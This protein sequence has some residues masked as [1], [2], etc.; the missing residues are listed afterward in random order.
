MVVSQAEPVRR[1]FVLR[2]VLALLGLV[3]LTVWAWWQR[4]HALSGGWQAQMLPGAFL[5]LCS[6]AA[7]GARFRQVMRLLNIKLTLRESLRIVSFAVFCQFCVPVG[8]GAELA[9]FLKLRGLAPERRALISASGVV[10]EH[11]IGLLALVATA[12]VLFAIFRPFA[13]TVPPLVVAIVAPTILVLAAMVLLRRQGSTRLDSTQLLAHKSDVVL[14]LGWS[15]LMQVL[16]AAAVYVGSLGWAMN[17]AYWQILF[18]LTTAGVLQAV[19][20]NLLGVGAADVAGTGLYVA[21]GLSVSHAILL[22]S[23][24]ISYRL[25]VVLFGGLWELDRAR[26]VMAG[27]A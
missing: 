9:K 17:I 14:A 5:A 6:L 2:A 4:P 7:Y 16:L 27:E 1:W 25:L 24:L 12:S 21:L 20:A 8:G 11:I 13:L 22:A 10:L 18:V 15:L 3:G 19:P 26:H 23:L